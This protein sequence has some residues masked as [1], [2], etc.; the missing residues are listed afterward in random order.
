[1]KDFSLHALIYATVTAPPDELLVITCASTV[2]KA[3]Y[4][5]HTEE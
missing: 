5:L 4:L 3:V 1:M 2:I